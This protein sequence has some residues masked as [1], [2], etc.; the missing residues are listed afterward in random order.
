MSW[1]EELITGSHL[2]CRY[3]RLV[4]ERLMEILVSGADAFQPVVLLILRCI[5]DSPGLDM[6]P[7]E[8][9]LADAQL[10]YPVA[11]LLESKCSSQ[12][13]EVGSSLP[14]VNGVGASNVLQ[15]REQQKPSSWRGG[16][17]LLFATLSGWFAWCWLQVMNVVMRYAARSQQQQGKPGTL[18]LPLSWPQC[19]DGSG[20]EGERAVEC[21]GR[22]VD[23]WHGR[24]AGCAR[25][26]PYIELSHAH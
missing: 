12:A 4:L 17:C 15:V 23:E 11:G 2:G 24:R 26:M 10:F 7:P 20:S 14:S 5:F 22:V 1:A 21:L 13:L 6:R 25:I 9:A 3:G 19:I 16:L 8:H 18:K